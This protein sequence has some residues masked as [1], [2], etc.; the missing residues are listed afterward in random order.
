ML[1]RK[2]VLL[3]STAVILICMC[4]I[5]GAT[6][7]LFTDGE[8]VV[9]HLSSGNLDIKFERTYLEYSVLNDEGVMIVKTHTDIVDFTETN[10]ATANVFGITEDR[11]IVPGS[12][13]KATFKV[14]HDRD[15][16]DSK[17][18][19]NVAFD[20]KVFIKLKDY[21][22]N[23]LADQLYVSVYDGDNN[24]V[25]YREKL[26]SARFDPTD[27]GY[28]H[29]FSGNQVKLSE[30][31]NFTILIEFENISTDKTNNLAQDQTVYFDLVVEAQQ[32][33]PNPI[34]TETTPETESESE[35]ATVNP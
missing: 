26:S 6:Y 33:V 19:S 7:A 23:H 13:I 20:Y 34:E 14:S 25:V 3:L 15:E 2:R 10:S 16:D 35:S 28:F 27:P 1:N 5:V 4:V 12:H 8:T 32:N 24:V 17:V 31:E 30:E 22:G 9:N 21:S 11:K 29:V 18:D